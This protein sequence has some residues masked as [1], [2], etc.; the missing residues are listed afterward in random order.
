MRALWTGAKKKRAGKP[1][2][3]KLLAADRGASL[4]T[5]P[6]KPFQRHGPNRPAR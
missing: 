3:L 4:A 5:Q 1:A 2:H 6:W